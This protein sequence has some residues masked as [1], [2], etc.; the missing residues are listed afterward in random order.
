[1]DI[2]HQ[3]LIP[4][5]DKS[6]HIEAETTAFTVPTHIEKVTIED[7]LGIIEPNGVLNRSFHAS[8]TSQ[9][10]VPSD[11]PR[12]PLAGHQEWWNKLTT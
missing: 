9:G 8:G 2:E 7:S 6:K 11:K 10:T 1:M 4:F 3:R 5:R 12:Y